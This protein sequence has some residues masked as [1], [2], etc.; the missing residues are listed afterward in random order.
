VHRKIPRAL[1]IAL[2]LAFL[3][4]LYRLSAVG[5]IGPDEPRYASIAREMARSG[6]WITPRLW[7]GPWFEKPPL[8]YWM[9]GIGFRLGLGPELAPRLPVALM[10][11]AFLI[12]YWWILNREFG[13]SAAWFAT[14]ILGTC[15]G[16]LGFSQV[17]VTDLPMTATFSAAMLLALPWIARRD[18]RFLPAASALLGLAVLAKSGVPIV[19]ALPLVW[20]GRKKVGVLAS[21][22]RVQGDPRG[23]EGPPHR[24]WL[25]RVILPLLIVAVPW[26]V[27]CY[28]RN[29]RIFPYTLFV[30]HQFQR[31]TS[32]ALQHSQRWWYYLPVFIGLLLPWSPL[33]LLLA[34]RAAFRDPRRQFL[35]AWVVF[36]LVFFSVAPNK[37]AGYVLPLL[38]AAA[39]LMALA[40]DE[41]AGARYWLAGCA[42]LLVAILVAA[43]ILPAAVASGLSRTPWPAFRW[44][45]LL[46]AGI[47]AMVWALDSQSRRLAAVLLIAAG[48]AAGMVYVKRTATPELDRVASART[49]WRQIA[50]RADQVCADNLKRDFRYGLN[51]YSE[52]PLPECG[53]RP[54]PWRVVQLP[55]SPPGVSPPLAGTVDLH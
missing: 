40:L 23:P 18:S 44:I 12:F 49:L 55:G 11:V 16:W 25:V 29:G 6:D 2:P 38:P 4:Y 48:A 24:Y 7:G 51:Y 43:P 3:S 41:T 31:L 1:W 52:V 47:A 35:L 36:G 20:W 10:A 28:L 53:D 33:L 37:L 21:E 30:Q 32:G 13:S 26:H 50:G 45:W 27:I 9:S 42:L 22:E 8:L 46:P 19:L 14:L 15:G 5:L 54:K 39:V 17:G 34:R